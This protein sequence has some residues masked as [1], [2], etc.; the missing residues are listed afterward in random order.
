MV[1]QKLKLTGWGVA[2]QNCVVKNGAFTGEWS[3]AQLNNAGVKYVILGHSERRSLY[4]ESDEVIAE[5]TVAALANGMLVI[6]CVGETLEQRDTGNTEVVVIRQVKAYADKIAPSDWKKIVIAYEPVWAIGTGAT[7]TPEQAQEVHQAIRS[8]IAQYVSTQV[9]STVRIIY[10]GSVTEDNAAS[11]YQQRDINGFLVGGASLKPTFVDVIAAANRPKMYAFTGCQ[12]QEEDGNYLMKHSIPNLFNSLVEDLVVK[13]PNDVAQFMVSQLNAKKPKIV[14][15]GI[16]GFGRIGRL[17][18]RAA[19]SNKKVQVVAVN[20]PFIDAPYME[21]MFKFDS[22]HGRYKGTV[23]HTPEG[24]LIIDGN[25]INVYC[26]KQP[27]LIPWGKHNVDYVVE[28]TG[29][30]TVVDKC[31]GHLKAGAKRVVIS[32]P[33]NDA[34]MYVMG[35]NEDKYVPQHTIISNASCTTNCLAPLARVIHESFGIVEGLMTT[36]HSTTATQK[37]CR[38]TK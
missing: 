30:F 17:V 36:V 14:R 7:A 33:S 38:R 11:L 1:Q 35:V 5:K 2:A 31:K 19:M 26:E 28:S 29:V 23:G 8:W 20:D 3:A 4:K 15:I 9:A 10:G 12:L 32:A 13:R 34:P 37:N 18:C 24:S 27:E 25:L 16:N 6:A 21:Y 22:T